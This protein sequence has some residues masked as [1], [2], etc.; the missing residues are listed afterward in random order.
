MVLRD[1]NE[2]EQILPFSKFIYN[3]EKAKFSSK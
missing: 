2:S 3:M 1:F